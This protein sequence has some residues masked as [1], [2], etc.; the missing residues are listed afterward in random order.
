MHNGL[1]VRVGFEP[2]MG[3]HAVPVFHPEQSA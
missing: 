3:G 2:T 1:R